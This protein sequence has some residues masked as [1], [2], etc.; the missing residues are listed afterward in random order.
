MT[1]YFIERAAADKQLPRHLEGW[2]ELRRAGWDVTVLLASDQRTVIAFGYSPTHS[3][4]RTK[5][6]EELA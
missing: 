3:S 2:K 6:M 1:D 5:L 4:T